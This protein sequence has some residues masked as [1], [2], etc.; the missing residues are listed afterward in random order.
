MAQWIS[1]A[2]WS[3]RRTENIWYQPEEEFLFTAEVLQKFSL[4]SN[5][6]AEMMLGQVMHQWMVLYPILFRINATCKVVCK[7]LRSWTSLTRTATSFN[8]WTQK[9]NTQTLVSSGQ[10]M[11]NDWDFSSLY[12][13]FCLFI[14]KSKCNMQS[15]QNNM[16]VFKACW[17]FSWNA[18]KVTETALQAS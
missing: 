5:E 14:F 18:I 7:F 4:D 1:V 11:K 9:I 2:T 3:S 17:S 16:Q 12:N 6:E 15:L 10:H 8:L 13:N